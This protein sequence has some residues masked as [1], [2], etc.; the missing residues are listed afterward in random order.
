MG[1]IYICPSASIDAAM[2]E[3]RDLNKFLVR[4]PPGM[5]DHI[6]SLAKENGRSM[7]AE[8]VY[9]LQTTLEMDAYVPK[10]NAQPEHPA[11]TEL[12]ELSDMIARATALLQRMEKKGE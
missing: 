1:I 4:M 2:I 11:R 6:A 10:E 3:S 8:I 12:R 5:R 9:R 7:N